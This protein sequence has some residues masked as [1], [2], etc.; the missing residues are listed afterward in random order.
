[1]ATPADF[2]PFAELARLIDHQHAVRLS[3]VLDHIPAQF[4][5]HGILIPIGLGQQPLRP[6]WITLS[7]GFGQLPAILPLNRGQ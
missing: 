7:H 4:L 3:Q 2:F 1:L 5:T 6:M